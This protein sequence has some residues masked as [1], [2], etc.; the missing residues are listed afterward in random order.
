MNRQ[1][2]PSSTASTSSKTHVRPANNINN[3]NRSAKKPKSNLTK[4]AWDVHITYIFISS[5]GLCLNLFY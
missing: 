2:V 3:V 1:R 4:P 5:I